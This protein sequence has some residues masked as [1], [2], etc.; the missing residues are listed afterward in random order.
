LGSDKPASGKEGPQM[1]GKKAFLVTLTCLGAM[2]VA[3]SAQA[4][5][6]VYDEFESGVSSANWTITT[7]SGTVVAR[8]GY[9]GS[10]GKAVE[11]AC[12]REYGTIASTASFA[13]PTINGASL[14]V[15]VD[16][17]N[18]LQF[19]RSMSTGIFQLASPDSSVVLALRGKVTEAGW[20]YGY[21][22]GSSLQWSDPIAAAPVATIGN[23]QLIRMT[24]TKVAGSLM[25][26]AT[27]SNDG[28]TTWTEIFSRAANSTPETVS[29]WLTGNWGSVWINDVQYEQVVPEPATM[30]LLILGGSAMVLKRRRR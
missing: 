6:M 19:S 18:L 16:Y 14:T 5:M 2:L 21:Y 12:G 10:D 29:V 3:S 22:E 7:P 1:V 30:G 4:E 8:S 11:L 9:A 13:V 28:G 25:Q 23:R 24:L 27:F 17:A 20:R 15:Q 26:S